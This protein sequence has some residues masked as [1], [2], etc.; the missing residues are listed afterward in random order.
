MDDLIKRALDTLDPKNDA[1]WT[2]G[3]LPSMERMKEITGKSDLTRAEVSAVAPGFDRAAAG[4]AANGGNAGE[5]SAGPASAPSAEEGSDLSEMFDEI[6]P[7]AMPEPPT[8]DQIAAGVPDAILL[9]EAFVI[10]AQAD[11]Y[12]R[13]QPMMNLVRAYQV[14]QGAIKAMQER[15]NLREA[16]RVAQHNAALQREADKR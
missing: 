1:H 2:N 7:L 10:A 9:F 6:P 8:A 13:N 15:L 16:D 3:G 14:E 4:E 12:R 5:G 11:K